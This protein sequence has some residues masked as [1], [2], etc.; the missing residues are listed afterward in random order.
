MQR[1]IFGAF[2]IILLLGIFLT[3]FLNLSLIRSSHLRELENRL[4]TNGLLIEQ[5][6]REHDG[7]ITEKE[8][9][10]IAEEYGK[11]I[12]ARITLIDDRGAVLADTRA[13]EEE[14]ENHAEREEVKAALEGNTGKAIRESVTV[15]EE[16]FYVAIPVSFQQS[17]LR[18]IRLAVNLRQIQQINRTLFYYIGISIL[19]GLLASL[20]LAYRFIHK[21]ME[22]IRDMTEGTKKIAN[23]GFDKR[24]E[25]S[26]DDEIGE[27]ADNFNHMAERLKVTI[28]QLSENN[29]KFKALLTSMK[30][31]I[32][33]VDNKHRLILLNP[34]AEELFQI[35]MEDTLGKH[36]LEVVRNN[37]LDDHLKEIFEN[38]LETQIEISTHEPEKILKIYSNPIKLEED[39]NKI[40]GIVALIEDVTEIRRLEKM[41]SDFVANVSH[42][43]KTPLTS[44]SGF[45]ET[46]KSGA[47]DDEDTKQRFLDIIDIETERLT[48][49]I[50]DILTLSEIENI[51]A[52]MVRQAISTS[53]V[54]SEIGEI[55]R[56]IAANKEIEL[57][58]QIEANLPII[59]GNGDW[60]KQMLINLVDN[61][62]KYTQNGGKVYLNAYQ[63][64]SN[65]IITVK[66]TGIGIPKKDIPR[67]FERFYRV[68]KARTRKVGGTGLGLAI[69]KH[70][71]L[72]LNG[73]IKVN[74]D[75]GK[76]TEFIVVIPVK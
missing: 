39:P 9:R 31:P 50:D 20:M 19:V 3:G 71:V 11:R 42:E 60:F 53:D 64:Y 49:L 72:S 69:V 65:I 1:K 58:T 6:L 76:G 17:D 23:G 18:V 12:N 45:V 26:S 8:L 29:T 70:I 54:L 16:M 61:A 38:N 66:D 22:P 35:R 40:I 24:I 27:L 47:I 46:L 4:V 73:R 41:R 75:V 62:I 48:R 5:F 36:I 32:V 14:M 52:R 2:F 56:P 33:A 7:E 10:R 15:N 44:I 37:V 63:K 25:V 13:K 34:A 21:I 30:N 55:M 43:L 74:S 67:L 51:Q 28:G 57:L 59:T 68:D